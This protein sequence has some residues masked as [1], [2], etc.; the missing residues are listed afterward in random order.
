[1]RKP[2][3]HDGAA[4]GFNI[5]PPRLPDGLEDVVEMVVPEMQRRGPYRTAYDGQALRENL[6]LAW[7]EHLAAAARRGRLAEALGS[8]AQ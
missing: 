8:A 6:G 4:D 7:P 3:G 1:M 5:L 2:G